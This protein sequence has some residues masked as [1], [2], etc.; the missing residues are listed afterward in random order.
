VQDWYALKV[1]A[2]ENGKPVLKT[3]ARILEDH[4]DAY[5]SDCAL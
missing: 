3:G 2:G 1:V 5:A 4:S